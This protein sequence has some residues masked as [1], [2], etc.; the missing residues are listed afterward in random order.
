ME[1]KNFLKAKHNVL[2]VFESTYNIAQSY[3][4]ANWFSFD[5]FLF[6]QH[7]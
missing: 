7:A 5:Y 2:V 6:I 4:M 1:L 3:Q